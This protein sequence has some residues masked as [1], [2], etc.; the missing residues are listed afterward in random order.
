MNS[1]R[2]LNIDVSVDNALSGIEVF[3]RNLRHLEKDDVVDK[4]E[5]VK[6]IGNVLT[7]RLTVRKEVQLVQHN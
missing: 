1:N 4:V 2:F 6:A 7:L 5:F 3:L